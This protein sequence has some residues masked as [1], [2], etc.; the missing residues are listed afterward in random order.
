MKFCEIEINVKK[1]ARWRIVLFLS[2]LDKVVYIKKEEI[3]L[4]TWSF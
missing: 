4:L 2:W 3:V 1:N